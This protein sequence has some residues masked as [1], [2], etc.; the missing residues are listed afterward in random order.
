[1]VWTPQHEQHEHYTHELMVAWK[2]MVVEIFFLWNV[3]F[4]FDE[5]AVLFTFGVLS[6]SFMKPIGVISIL[7]T[8]SCP[9]LPFSEIIVQINKALYDTTTAG[10][11][12]GSDWPTILLWQCCSIA[13][14]SPT[15]GRSPISFFHSPLIVYCYANPF[16]L[17]ELL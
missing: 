6:A 7:E 8:F 10:P 9:F 12:I 15:G 5:Q 2:S 16:N 13:W 14:N 3:L 1:M 11:I 4:F 17:V